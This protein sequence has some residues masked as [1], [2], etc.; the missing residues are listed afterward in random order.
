V[1]E[2]ANPAPRGASPRAL[3]LLAFASIWFVWG[4]TFLVIRH[5]IADIPPILMCGI[6]L[7][8]AGLLL[9]AWARARGEA[10]PRGGEWRNAAL[11]GILLPGIGNTAVT[12]GIGHV[13]SGLVALLVSTIPLWMG[14]LSSLGPEAEPPGRRA[15]VGLALGFAG[16]ALLIGPG[17]VTG[18]DA[19]L[20]PFWALVPVAGSL[21]WAWGS[22]WSRRVALPRSPLVSTGIGLLAS[23]LALLVVSLA[24]GDFASW[25]PG[26]VGWGAWASVAYLSVFGSVLA[27]TAY[28]YLLA[29]VEPAKVATYAF[30]NPIVAML[31]GFAFGG[32]TLSPRTLVAAAVVLA[33]VWLITTAPAAR[34]GSPRGAGVPA[35]T[36]AMPVRQR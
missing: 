28:V 2:A 5:A 20:S 32:E 3:L 11:V 22:L 29:R 25:R 18:R 7:A 35:G 8:S 24:V 9:L 21:S 26:E 23:G 27:F 36:G 10:W 4:S 30:V 19:T 34:A 14:L 6:R 12:L 31:L 13:P 33:A 16:I 17:L 15:A 1:P